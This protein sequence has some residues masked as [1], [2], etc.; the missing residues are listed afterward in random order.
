MSAQV[1]AACLW[2]L[3][4]QHALTDTPGQSARGTQAWRPL[5][6]C[7]ACRLAC[8]HHET[9]GGPA[10]AEGPTPPESSTALPHLGTGMA[11]E[12]P[13]SPS[14]HRQTPLPLSSS[15]PLH[16]SP[17]PSPRAHPGCCAFPTPSGTFSRV[18]SQSGLCNSTLYPLGLAPWSE[19]REHR[20]SQI[21]FSCSASS[22]PLPPV[23]AG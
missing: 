14:P 15:D 22:R 23:A 16:T 18:G 13:P 17:S 12:P 8:F 19:S 3:L 20:R 11:M 21:V 6:V 2:R 1:Q 7:R 5:R 10:A 4:Q 9:F